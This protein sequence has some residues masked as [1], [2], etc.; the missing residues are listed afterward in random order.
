VNVC[1]TP[2]DPISTVG[3]MAYK[4]S[5]EKNNEKPSTTL[6][7]KTTNIIEITFMEREFR[8]VHCPGTQHQLTN[9]E[10]ICK[11]QRL[12]SQNTCGKL[13]NF[14]QSPQ[15]NTRKLVIVMNFG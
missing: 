11:V 3:L 9:D 5:K 2:D 10:D 14:I 1:P 4:K 6:Y 7:L 8:Q 12:G 13:S 15:S